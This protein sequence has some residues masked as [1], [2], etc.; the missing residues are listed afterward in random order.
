M[1]FSL[2]LLAHWIG[3]YA[4]QTSKMALGKSQHLKWLGIH[5]LTYTGTL[6]AFCIFIF[7]FKTAIVYTL[8]NGG[9]HGVTDFFTSKLAA[10][11]ND[12][13][14]I[15]FPILGMDQLIHTIT[16]YVTYQNIELLLFF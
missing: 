1:I 13:P 11:Y 4:F 7:S 3:D 15:F 8:V 2:I 6:F 14:R 9:L 5:I 10:R 12:T 16:L